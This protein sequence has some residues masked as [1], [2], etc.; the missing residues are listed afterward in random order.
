M[1]VARRSWSE[2]PDGRVVSPPTHSRDRYSR[3][4]GAA[5]D[6]RGGIPVIVRDKPTAWEVFFVLRGSLVQKILPQIAFVAGL[7]LLVVTL[8][9]SGVTHIPP[10]T[11]M[12]LSVIGAALAI[13]AAF[14]NAAAYDRW[15]E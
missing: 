3:R 4:A 8:Q 6:Y 2:A 13:F 7:S 14:R 10:I 1:R 11:P 12:A 9:R 15:R 5:D